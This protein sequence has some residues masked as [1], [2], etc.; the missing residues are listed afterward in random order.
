MPTPLN[1][2][3]EYVNPKWKWAAM[4]KNGAVYFYEK[5]PAI[6]HEAGSWNTCCSHTRAGV[7]YINTD[8]INWELSLTK[9][10]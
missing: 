5:E 9:R 4:D 8:D 7:L 10:L 3:W 2:P 1:I 6:L